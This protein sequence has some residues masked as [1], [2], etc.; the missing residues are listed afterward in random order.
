MLT[1]LS[2]RAAALWTRGRPMERFGYAVAA[3]LFASGLFHVVVYLVDG[4]PWEGPVSW[5]KAV[6][7]GLSFGMT[8]ACLVWVSSYVAMR[9]AVRR[10]LL[11]VFTAASVAEV[12]GI[13]VQAWRN[14]PSHFNYEDGFSSAIT[15]MLAGGGVVIVASVL[16]LTILS[17]RAAPDTAPSMRLAVR[18]GLVILMGAMVTGA[19]M[20]AVGVTLANGGEQQ[21]AYETAGWLKPAHAVTMHAVG[22]LPVLAFVLSCTRLDERRRTRI[23]ACGVAAYALAALVTVVVNLAAGR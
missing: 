18:A 10:V 21:A 9:P 11:G 4:G 7:F 15:G 16:A 19:V 5:R 13:T 20:I 6:T 17:L 23:V 8:L 1:Q 12:T 14:V 3:V 2:H 22:V